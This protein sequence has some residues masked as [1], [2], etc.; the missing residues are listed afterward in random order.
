[1]SRAEKSKNI[2]EGVEV[3]PATCKGHGYFIVDADQSVWDVP[4]VRID[5]AGC[6]DCRREPKP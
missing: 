4:M 5:C 3:V 6:V 2:F 1:M